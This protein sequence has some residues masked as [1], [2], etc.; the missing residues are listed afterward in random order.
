MTANYDAMARDRT[1]E[2]L[3]ATFRHFAANEFAGYAPLYENLSRGIAEDPAILR[4]SGAAAIGQF[5][6]NLLFA[7]VHYLL[8]SGLDAPIARYFATIDAEPLAPDDG[9]YPSFRA[10]CLENAT[11]ISDLMA[12]RLVQTNEVGRSACLLPAFAHVAQL[13]GGAPLALIDVGAA[14]GLNL[15]FD[16][17]HFDYGALTWGAASSPVRLYSEL[18]SEVK[19]PLQPGQ[20]VVGYRVGVDLNPIDVTDADEVRWLRALVWPD[21]PQRAKALAAAAEL[22][23]RDSPRIERGDAGVLLPALI[24][25]APSEMTLCVYHSFALQQFPP[26]SRIAFD[27]ALAR[28]A[29]TR[30][31]YLL[32]M[33]GSTLLAY[34]RLSSWEN[35]TPETVQLAECAA[36]GQWLR[37]L[38]PEEQ[39]GSRS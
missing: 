14:A 30:P 17:Y 1:P 24:D 39:E 10:F 35:G 27:A 13:G 16:R 19:P 7:A 38:S 31:V 11:Q 33:G 22:A 3:A 18:R 25:E 26:A 8:L 2:A 6:P 4:L 12:T 20:P 29:E 28:A 36:H 5:P 23:R 37:W 15:L 21:Q 32:G 34:V 9:A